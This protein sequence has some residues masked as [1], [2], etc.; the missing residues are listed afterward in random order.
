LPR[1]LGFGNEAPRLY[2][3]SVKNNTMKATI[4]FV[5]KSLTN[6]V[7][8]LHP[9]G[10]WLICIG[11]VLPAP[12]R[13][14]QFLTWSGGSSGSGN[15]S[16]AAN[17]D[18]IHTPG[19][20][21]T[22]NFPGGQPRLTN[23]NNI[24]N[25][26]LS[27]ILFTGGSGG[28]ALYGGSSITLT[29][30]NRIDATNTAGTAN[31]IYMPITLS[32]RDVVMNVSN[33]ATLN[34]TCNLGGTVGVTKVGGGTLNY[35]APYANTYTGTTWVQAGLL[36]V[37][38]TIL[39]DGGFGGPLI[40][41]TGTSSATVRL[42]L[43]DEIPNT[44]PVTLNP[45][46]TLDLN[47]YSDTIG[48]SV[49]LNGGGAT[50]QTGAGTLTLAPNTTIT[51]TD[52]PAVN[53]IKG[54][55]N[56]GASGTCT[57]QGTG[58]ANIYAAVSGAANIVKN[59]SAKLWFDNANT[60]TGSLT[61]NGS[62]YI[63]V[64]TATALGNT[65]GGTTING[66]VRLVI[67]AGVN[68]TNE[69][70]TM[71]ST[72]AN[73][74]IWCPSG[75]CSWTNPTITLSV[76]T[77][78][79]IDS[80]AALS[81]VGLITGAGGITKTG[82]GTLTLSGAGDNN[83][84]GP[85][86][87]NAGVLQ[88]DHSPGYWAIGSSS[89]ITIGDGLGGG[90]ADIVR[91]VNANGNQIN[92]GVPITINSSGLLDLNGH[93]DDLGTL[94][95]NGGDISTGS[96]MV[97]HTS[98]GITAQASSRR[99]S[100]SGNFKMYSGHNVVTVDNGTVDYNLQFYANVLDDGN[101]FSIVGSPNAGAFVRLL[102]SN[103]FT[104]PLIISNLSVDVEH[105]NALGST[106]SP[107]IVTN[108]SELWIYWTGI[109]NETVG[110]A[111][112]AVLSAQYD[113][114]WTGPVVL[115]GDA[116]IHGYS[117]GVFD[118]SG[119][120]SGTGNL[121]SIASATN[122]FSGTLANTYSGTTT[123]SSGT[124]ELN[125]SGF[126]YAIP[127]NLVINGTV[128]N[129]AQSQIANS[130]AVT[131]GPSG[132]LDLSTG[133]DA[134]ASLDGGGSINIGSKFINQLGTGSH[135]YNGVISG[136]GGTLY[137]DGPLTSTL[138]GN[139]TYTG[140]TD[141][142]IGMSGRLIINGY[143]P[144]SDVEVRSSMT[145]GGTG[146]VGDITCLGTVAPGTG[147][148]PGILTC[149]N[150]TFTSAG[151]FNV[152]V[153]GP[154]AGTDYDQ[155]N[156]RGTNTLANAVLAPDLT[157]AK[158][159]AVG[160]KFTIIKND[161]TDPINGIFA[162]YPEGTT[163]A[164]NGYEAIISYVGGNGNDVEFTL[165]RV[166]GAVAGT[167]VSLGNGS[168]TI[169]PNECNYLNVVI[170][171]QTGTAMS[172]ISARLASATPNVAVTQPFS[173]YPNLPGSG[174]GTNTTPFQISTSPAFVCGTTINLSLTVTSP[175]H[176]SFTVPVVLGSGSPAALPL[177]YDVSALTNIPD[178]GTI[179]STNL[180]SSFSGP[181]KKVAVSLWLTHPIDSDLSLSLIAPD[182]TVVPLTINV[183]AGANFGTA[184]SPD[185]VRTTFDDAAATSI[186]AG[187]PPFVGTFRPQ[188]TLANFI[189]TTGNGNWR[190]RV[191]DSVGGS[192]GA[193][194]C[195][196]LFLYPVTCTAG[197]GLCE[198]CPNITL[199]GATGPGTPTQTGYVLFNSIAS[200]CAAPKSCPG[201]FS[202]GVY[203]SDNY[204]FRN[205]PSAAC[206]NVT[207]ENDSPTAA[208]LATAY[209]GSYSPT[210]ADKCGNYLADS[211]FSLDAGN[212]IR[213]FS[214]TVAANATFVVNIIANTTATTAPY[215]LTVSG[216][217]CRPVLT[218]AP[219]G[220]G[221]V[222]LDW[223]TAAAGYGLEQTNR[224]NGAAA[225]WT[226]VTNVPAVI[227]SRFVVTNTP[228]GGSQFY[229]LHQK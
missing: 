76:P 220:S 214:F 111:A 229:Q 17:W 23:T 139:N 160:Q 66:T 223:T 128:R 149:S 29:L 107:T 126:D 209:L 48:S 85:T 34:L 43:S 162:A 104:G 90:D 181:V 212:P 204:T 11:L 28:Y 82:P 202:T 218:A 101:G 110:L 112:G 87:I 31:T 144:Q 92:A 77:T 67:D 56:V 60:F 57:F 118:I 30:T 140:L 125:K 95:I 75:A 15:W 115:S 59:D 145:L 97:N 158:P 41:G 191:T 186:T 151:R 195:W 207:V 136:T 45:G 44:V 182:G 2:A 189:N 55:L 221:K 203:P 24:S 10:F 201:T 165:T 143:Q 108:N 159:V 147:T 47:G 7:H 168:G 131:I 198:L 61:A 211:G 172:G 38:N 164:Q 171:N 152:E 121:N 9:A 5:I 26:V 219:A 63:E 114:F 50:L 185:T 134:V 146:T 199:A 208:M 19:N 166:P 103:A 141:L 216:G 155:L 81:L 49:A 65:S 170:T 91:Y 176:G 89:S 54:N 109:T 124:L 37:A 86:V 215:T 14:A 227:N 20:G 188:G 25:L 206:V 68:V 190:L 228:A 137:L 217:D 135:T 53:Y 117:S 116:T 175:T 157:F 4:P 167:A 70:L 133:G 33:T 153:T 200:T 213:T 73:G 148:G 8:R 40:I 179:E 180:V 193:L 16:D 58:S 72:Y 18:N 113:C 129:L 174:K 88:L 98:G 130:G 106:S 163:Y 21:D 96:G 12:G 69:N 83:Y 184:C 177:R 119:V 156:V 196:S 105:P 36:T 3:G 210:N 194:R 224:L 51:L 62:G 80:G 178:T 35:S 132:Y 150:L 154:T 99:A 46:S 120:I 32:T 64:G 138:N 222:R 192:V 226:P 79:Q 142:E 39:V 102:S 52:D 183:G 1:P 6:L 22:L 127:H 123:V 169:D 100:I 205:G 93:T 71:N 225:N 13:A 84:T 122:R 94:I 42:N 74:A 78:M 161:G 173:A 187:A 197:G 27:Q